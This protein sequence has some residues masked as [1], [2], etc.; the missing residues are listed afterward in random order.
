MVY[1]DIIGVQALKIIPM[2]NLKIF[3]VSGFL[4]W[5]IESVGK[6]GTDGV[7]INP[8]SVVK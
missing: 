7:F 1:F 6:F 5:A 2:S 3:G 4:F 8:H